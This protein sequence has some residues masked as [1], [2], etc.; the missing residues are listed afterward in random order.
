M[1][2]TF[3]DGTTQRLAPPLP[4]VIFICVIAVKTRAGWV[5][6]RSF[7]LGEQ[8]YAEV[9]ADRIA[10]SHQY[11]DVQVLPV[12]AT[13]QTPAWSSRIAAFALTV[14]TLGLAGAL[15]LWTTNTTT[16]LYHAVTAG[17]GLL[18]VVT[19]ICAL[20]AILTVRRNARR[21]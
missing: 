6:S 3:P 15:V 1:N 20:A 21:G 13:A 12:Q 7:R 8:E 9:E 11:E 2:V 14:S 4:G 10:N 16:P 5:I 17:L 19:S 18:G